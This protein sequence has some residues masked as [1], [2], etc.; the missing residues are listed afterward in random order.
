M[1]RFRIKRVRGDPQATRKCK[2]FEVELSN[3]IFKM[4]STRKGDIQKRNYFQKKKGDAIKHMMG[5]L[6]SLANVSC[7]A[8]VLLVLQ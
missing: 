1:E 8:G 7:S 2:L 6:A 4:H 3:S 5:L